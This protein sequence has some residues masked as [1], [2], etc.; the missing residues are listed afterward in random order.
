M[1]TEYPNLTR[2]WV[3]K[4]GIRCTILRTYGSTEVFPPEDAD[5][6]VDNAATG[7]TLREHGLNV[8]DVLMRSSTCLVANREALEGEAAGAIREMVTLLES[9]LLARRKVLLEMNV[10]VELVDEILPRLPCM[11]APTVAPLYGG[12]GYAIKIAVDEA[13]APAL[14]VQLK[15]MGATDILQYRLERIV[16]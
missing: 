2:Q 4:Q 8:L 1:A 11:K 10:P 16:P 15:R 9:A 7:R 13:E 12:A 6:I 5:M 14:V 3:S